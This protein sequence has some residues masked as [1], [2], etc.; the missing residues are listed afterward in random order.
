ME[1]RTLLIP[2][3]IGN[4]YDLIC[5][6]HRRSALPAFHNEMQSPQRN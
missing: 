3:A 5:A 2:I 1:N 4:D 6:N